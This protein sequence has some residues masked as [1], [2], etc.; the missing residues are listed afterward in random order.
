M[1]ATAIAQ[2]QLDD[3][4]LLS[5]YILSRALFKDTVLRTPQREREHMN[6]DVKKG[7]MRGTSR[8]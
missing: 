2:F 1:Q 8:T 3:K 4:E 5:W 6:I 7:A